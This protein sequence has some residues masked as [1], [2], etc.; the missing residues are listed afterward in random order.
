MASASDVAT[1]G[2][3]ERQLAALGYRQQ[4]SRSLGLLSNFSVGFTYL[5]PVVGVYTL[6]AFGAGDRRTGI[7]LVVP[8]R[9]GRA[10][11]RRLHVR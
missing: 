6:F 4:L 7:H 2:A 10:V 1:H 5:S 11:P 9:P 3:D 8:D